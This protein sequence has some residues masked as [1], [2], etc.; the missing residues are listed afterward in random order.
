[1]TKR[2]YQLFIHFENS[3]I[4]KLTARIIENGKVIV[5]RTL[6][7]NLK[8]ENYLRTTGIGFSNARVNILKS[9]VEL[10]AKSLFEGF[11]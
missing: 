4:V 6:K 5:E 1:M 11:E 3:Y 7:D 2:K 9:I 10:N 8:I